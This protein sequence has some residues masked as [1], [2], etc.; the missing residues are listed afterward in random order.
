M[1]YETGTATSLA[2]LLSK[3]NTFAAA[4]GWTVDEFDTVG[5]DWALSKGTVFVSARWN[6]ATPLELSIHQALAFSGTGTLPGNHTDDSGN[7]FNTTSSHTNT[8]LDNERHVTHIGNGPFLAYHFFEKDS[9]PAYLHVSVEVSAGSWRH[10]G[11]GTMEKVGTWTGGEYA[12]G[13]VMSTSL[14]HTAVLVSESYLLDGLLAQSGGMLDA[15]TIHVEGLPNQP[16]SGKWGVVGGSTSA[17]STG[18]DTAGIARER[19]RGGFRSGPVARMFGL[20]SGSSL[21]GLI[22][23][24]KI[25]IFHD[26]GTAT[27]RRRLLGYMPDVRGINIRNFAAGQEVLIGADTYVMLPLAIRTSD[28]VTFRTYF[29]GIAY[30]KVT[31]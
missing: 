27:T 31:A 23:L 11:F 17:T 15:A 14:L 24:Y 20:F 1:A 25:A 30:K 29:S 26:D 6:V 19:I 4:N 12:Y 7:G 10:F 13:Q 18:L 22:P 28:N 21:T 9:G 3:L 5:G 16:G 2:D 8:D